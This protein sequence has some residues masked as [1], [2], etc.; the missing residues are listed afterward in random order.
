MDLIMVSRMTFLEK[1]G[2]IACDRDIQRARVAGS[3][4]LVNDGKVVRLVDRKDL[5]IF[6]AGMKL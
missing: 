2:C 5:E 3:D 4:L 6:L 1:I